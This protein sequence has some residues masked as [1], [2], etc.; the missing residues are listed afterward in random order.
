MREKNL[1]VIDATAEK[2]A[3]WAEEIWKLANASL[4][5]ETESVSGVE[6]PQ[7]GLPLRSRIGT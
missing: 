2:E 4:V 1:S 5:S 3:A 7:G 6:S